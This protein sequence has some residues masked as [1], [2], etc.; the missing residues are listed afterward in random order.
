M[1]QKSAENLISAIDRSKKIQLSRFLY[2]LGIRHVGENIADILARKWG[3]LDAVMQQT[4]ESLAA[5][6]GIGKTIAESAHGFFSDPGN[7]EILDGI[8]KSGVEILSPTPIAVKTL[9]GKSF[10]LTGTLPNLTRSQAKALIEASGGKVGNAVSRNTSYLIAGEAAG[11]KLE[12]A[13]KIGVE[14]I[15]EAALMQLVAETTI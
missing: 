10:V 11:S 7:R 3:S 1:G 4:P 6:E 12:A 5:V 9:E 13:R 8:L 14:I 15:D 2:S